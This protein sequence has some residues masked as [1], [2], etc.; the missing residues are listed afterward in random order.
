MDKN[1]P[2][3]VEQM[4]KRR[5]SAQYNKGYEMDEKPVAEQNGHTVQSEDD[6]L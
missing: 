6:K 2:N 4:K 5:E 1:E 3:I